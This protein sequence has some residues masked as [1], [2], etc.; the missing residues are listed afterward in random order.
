MVITYFTAQ[1]VNFGRGSNS[2]VRITSFLNKKFS[3]V[4]YRGEVTEIIVRHQRI[5]TLTNKSIINIV[6]RKQCQ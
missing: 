5:K 6:K 1:I 3:C 2:C 4:S